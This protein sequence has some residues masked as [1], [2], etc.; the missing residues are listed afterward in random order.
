MVPV[1]KP[2]EQ[3]ALAVLPARE[4]KHDLYLVIRQSVAD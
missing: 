3:V 2:A 4:N 1:A